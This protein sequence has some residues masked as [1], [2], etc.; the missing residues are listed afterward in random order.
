[1]VVTT[2]AGITVPFCLFARL[3]GARVIFLETMARV[4]GPSAS[5][6]VLSRLA[7]RT[8]VQW[9]EVVSVYPRSRLCNPA[10]LDV[11]PA[12]PPNTGQGTFVAVGTHDQPFDRLLRMVDTAAS[13]GLL[14]QPI[15]VQAGVSEYRSES[16]ARADWLAPE[17]M[18]AEIRRAKFVVVHAGSG[19]VTTALRHGSRPLVLSRQAA[20]GEHFDDHQNQLTSKLADLGLVVKLGDEITAADLRDAQQPLRAIDSGNVPTISEALA[21]ELT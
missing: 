16:F 10:L 20:F 3:F 11:V 2:G 15:L 21:A 4:T 8:L 7:R 18:E 9:P 17:E 12:D 5:G 13:A 14:P 19:L 1:L 6:R